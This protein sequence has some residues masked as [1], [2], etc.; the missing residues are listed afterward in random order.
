MIYE[1]SLGLIAASLIPAAFWGG[2][3]WAK[4]EDPLES[5]DEPNHRDIPHIEIDGKMVPHPT[6]VARR[7]KRAALERK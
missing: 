5:I 2:Y 3:Q 1:I 6:I 7:A 4:A